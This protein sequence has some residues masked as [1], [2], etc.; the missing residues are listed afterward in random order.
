MYVVNLSRQT[1]QYKAA[2]IKSKSKHWSTHMEGN[3]MTKVHNGSLSYAGAVIQRAMLFPIPRVL[4]RY[5]SEHDA[6]PETVAAVECE[7]KR[8]LALRALHPT[9]RFPLASGPVDELWHTFLLF[10]VPYHEFCQL[11]AG[12][13]IHHHPGP[14]DPTEAQVLEAQR[15]FD[16]F[17][18]RYR[19]T[20]RESPRSDLWP[21]IGDAGVRW[22]C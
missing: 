19:S 6:A 22:S 11:I 14:L 18:D 3:V 8:Y 2:P 17:V 7:M 4:E 20:F 5:L 21:R 13:F 15:D 16:T 9:S 1:L 10:T 12:G